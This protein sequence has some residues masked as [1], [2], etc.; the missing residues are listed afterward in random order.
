[1]IKTIATG[2]TAFIVGGALPATLWTGAGDLKA[3]E[4]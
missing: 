4:D 3:I 1:M 2:A